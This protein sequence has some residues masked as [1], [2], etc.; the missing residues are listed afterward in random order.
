LKGRKNHET[1]DFE[2]CGKEKS[3][4]IFLSFLSL[5]HSMKFKYVADTNIYLHGLTMND[6]KKIDNEN[7]MN[8]LS[9]FHELNQKVKMY[10]F[11]FEQL[12]QLDKD[13]EIIFKD[14][15]EIFPLEKFESTIELIEKEIIECILFPL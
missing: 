5:F 15:E 2:K 4:L 14:L 7:V 1:L 12:A 9:N 6:E 13:I 10:P 3:L 8:F 11:K